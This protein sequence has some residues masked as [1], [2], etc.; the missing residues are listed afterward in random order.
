MGGA[1]VDLNGNIIAGTGWQDICTRFHR[2]NKDSLKNCIESDLHL[3]QNIKPGEYSIYKCIA[4]A[5][6]IEMSMIRTHS[7]IGYDI[8]NKIDFGYPLADIILQHHER[9]DGSGYP[10]KLK[11]KDICF[12]AKIFL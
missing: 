6:D 2:S 9:L 4:I 3:T 10:N 1:I 7:Q 8:L 12:E 11:D 5:S